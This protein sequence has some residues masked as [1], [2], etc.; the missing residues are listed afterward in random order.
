MLKRYC[1]LTLLLLCS[2]LSVT[3][4]QWRPTGNLTV[5]SE[6]GLPFYLI[7][8]GERYNDVPQT[9][10]RVEELPNP[11]YNCKIIFADKAQREIS[12][13]ALSLADVD[14]VMQDVTYRIKRDNKGRNVLRYY[15]NIPAQQNMP[16]PS[17]CA[18]YRYGSPNI[19]LAG[20][21]FTAAANAGGAQV[22]VSFRGANSP[23][24]TAPG[25]G[26]EWRDRG[27]DDAGTGG[28]IPV[29]NLRNNTAAGPCRT[30]MSQND[31]NDARSSV[32]S[33]SFD[34]TRL[35]TAKQIV[36]AN[37]MSAAQIASMISVFSFE[38]SRLDFAKYA[39]P[40]CVDKNNYY[41]I[42]NAF[43]FESSRS[44][45]NNYVQNLR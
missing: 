10:I 28:S 44:E 41:K 42:N 18:V 15:S 30:A 11:Y 24:G 43:T 9:N 4:A 20:P 39:Y 21:G 2:A 38:S 23:A 31:F 45:L 7:L 34:D 33:S 35:S 12:K 40:F 5:F 26:R 19:L 25:N 13:S 29:Q 27:R 32:A 22:N 1:L 16:R 8:N 36:S 6:D 37:C 17:N 3:Y 14:G